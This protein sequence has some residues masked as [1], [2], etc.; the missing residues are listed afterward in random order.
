MSI[1]A[2]PC[3]SCLADATISR[4]RFLVKTL[5]IRRSRCS[6]SGIIWSGS[7]FSSGVVIDPSR[8]LAGLLLGSAPFACR[9]LN[10]L[11]FVTV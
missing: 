5:A 7:M 1:C 3:L 9:E 6:S 4:M 8:T 11:A 2:F 10:V